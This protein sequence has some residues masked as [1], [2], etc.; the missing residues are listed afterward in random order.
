M[1]KTAR[2]IILSAF[3][4][5]PFIFSSAYSAEIPASPAVYWAQTQDGWELAIHRYQPEPPRENS[6]P[7]V[8]FNGLGANRY[9]F[10]SDDR[11]SMARFLARHGLDVWIGE[12]RGM[13]LSRRSDG[14]NPDYLWSF[15]DFIL[16]DIPAILEKVKTET[17]ARQLDWVGHSM[18]GM[19]LYAYLER[20]D[21]SLIRRGVAIASP[22]SFRVPNDILA[23]QGK[24]SF[25]LKIIDRI[26]VKQLIKVFLLFHMEFGSTFSI[27]QFNQDNMDRDFIRQLAPKA[28]ENLPARLL[29]Q[30]SDAIK[31]DNFSAH[32]DKYDY[33]ANL[34]RIKNPVLLVAGSLDNLVSPAGVLEVYNG[35]SSP[36]KEMVVAGRGNGFHRD[37][38]HI[39]L[40]LGENAREEIFPLVLDWL[41]KQ[42]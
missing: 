9:N 2:I 10:E 41:V 8:M 19:E 31:E 23:S 37:Y 11:H 17:H 3:L 36:R 15:E 13:G 12:C 14:K 16:T 5:L 39:D 25:F 30:F 35:I 18:G 26:P 6:V 28:V 34:S 4:F 38:G 1:I 40:L 24:L 20:G 7:V 29:L 22:V 27:I 32:T 42:P 21:A 33:S